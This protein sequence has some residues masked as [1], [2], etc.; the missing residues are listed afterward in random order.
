M[1]LERAKINCLDC[2][3]RYSNSKETSEI[4]WRRKLIIFAQE[5][6]NNAMDSLE[7]ELQLASTILS[8]ENMEGFH[9][10]YKNR[11]VG[12]RTCL[13][14]CNNCDYNKPQIKDYLKQNPQVMIK[15]PSD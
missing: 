2:Y 11:F 15:T 1:S 13:R 3:E 10:E 14:E 9:D 7:K 12:A 6:R 4:D 5:S 8:S